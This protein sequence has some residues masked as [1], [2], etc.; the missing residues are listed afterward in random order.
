MNKLNEKY[1]EIVKR[2]SL[3]YK[4]DYEDLLKRVDKYAEEQNTCSMPTLYEPFFY[5]KNLKNEFENISKKSIELSNEVV[6]KFLEDEN[7]RK[8]FRFE[9]KLE[10]L[11]MHKPIIDINIPIARYDM[12]YNMKNRDFKFCEFNTDGSSAMDENRIL[13]QEIVKTKAYKELQKDYELETNEYFFSFIKKF[14]DYVQ[15]KLKQQNYTVAI[16]DIIE[17][18]T[19][20]D[21]YV[22]KKS[23]EE[24]GIKTIICD[25]RDLYY[26]GKNL[27]YKDE[28]IDVVYRRAV[29][30]E[31]M[32]HYDE[33][34]SFLNAYF[35]NAFLMIGSFRS[36]IMHTKTTYAV[37]H[38]EYTEKI[39]S[40]KYIDFIKN[41]IPYTAHF[42]NE[43]DFYK[44]LKN[45][46]KYILKPD[47]GYKSLGVFTGKNM[48][49]KEFEKSCKKAF[50]NGYIYQ[51]YVDIKKD[52]Y[53]Y[54]D[55]ENGW[56]LKAFDT[57]IGMYIYF[58]DFIAP[59]VR[60]GNEKIIS[61]RF[62]YYIEP[63]IYV[64]GEIK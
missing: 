30:K 63:S 35:D 7:F 10:K 2:D 17:K 31:V 29:T 53:L 18:A 52:E 49:E 3:E 37:L 36:H 41:H 47:D 6:K 55:E 21:F 27:I 1:L 23:F 16:C 45:K 24:M 4:K 39:L 11:I 62:D 28:V 43:E 59:Y 54:Y 44:V 42:E 56:K 8:L 50:K 22:F 46:E 40:K 57:L 61:G 64:K 33:V 9:K 14:D 51:E 19:L 60:I 12:F 34:E 20:N 25:I 32:D 5:D 58:E 13:T 48:D 15:N 26:D 38:H